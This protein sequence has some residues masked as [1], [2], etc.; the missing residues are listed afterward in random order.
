M[1]TRK[2]SDA[3]PAADKSRTLSPPGGKTETQSQMQMLE[4]G[5][6]LFREERFAEAKSW[7]D[8]AAQGPQANVRLTAKTHLSVCE[9]RLKR[10][11]LELSSADDHYNYGVERLNAR[12]L[13]AARRHL[14]ISLALRPNTDYVLYAFAGALALSGDISA[15]Y[16]NLR[17]A[18]ELNPANRNAARQDPDFQPVSHNPLFSQLLHPERHPPY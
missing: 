8:K 5:L 14:E 1:A 17:R 10:P 2:K 6:R 15:S 13:E 4:Q 18:I 3:L 9:R 7:F 16:E 12:D 11:V